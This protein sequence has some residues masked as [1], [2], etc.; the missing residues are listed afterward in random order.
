LGF[1]GV[2]ARAAKNLTNVAE[3]TEM[4]DPKAFADAFNTALQSAEDTEDAEIFKQLVGSIDPENAGQR[5]VW[6]QIAS[7]LEA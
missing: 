6:E 7:N 2:T 5:E 1:E 3:E 4:N